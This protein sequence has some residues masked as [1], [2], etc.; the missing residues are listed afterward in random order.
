MFRKVIVRGRKEAARHWPIIAL[1]ALFGMIYGATLNAYGMFLWDESEYA[2]IARSALEGHGFAIGDTPNALRPPILPLAGAAGMLL[3]GERFDDT[4]LREVACFFALLALLCVYGFA[5]AAVD[6]TTGLAAA[7][8]L[9]ISPFFWIFVPHFLSEIPFLAF[10]AAAVWLFYL[11]AYRDERFFVWSWVSWALALLT[12]YTA[13]LFLP[14]I[15]SFIPLVLWL[16]GPDTRRR[17]MSRTF[18]LSPLAGFLVLTPWLIR[19]YATF[20]NPLAGLLQASHQLQDYLPG[21]SMPWHSYLLWLPAMLSPA[22]TVL[23]VAGVIWALWRRDSFV[24]HNALVAVVIVIWFSCYRYKEERMVSSA[25]PFVA[26]IAAIALRK[27]TA[28]L[29][30]LARGVTIGVVLAAFFVLSLRATRPILERSFTLGYPSFL[31]A[32]A[33]L[34]LE[35]SPGAVVLGANVPQIHWYSGL[36]AVN[37]PE[38]SELP[39]ALRHSEW[40]VITNFERVQKPYVIRLPGRVTEWAPDSAARFEDRKYV[41]LVIRSDLLLR[42]LAD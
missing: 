29:R 38:E 1:L 28:G 16:G 5:S 12:R 27:A 15:V 34:R 20:G 36:R 33:Y 39:Q 14:V 23:C 24:L 8:L 10:F 30:P 32:M 31:D 37:I 19:E 6:R 18:L 21:I 35:A 25:L 7:A 4:P 17:I 41:T 9:G 11:G 40:V 2:S 3:T 13:A 42:S 26:V 22:I